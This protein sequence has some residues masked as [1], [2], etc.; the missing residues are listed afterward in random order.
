MNYAARKFLRRTLAFALY[1]S[2]A[3]HLYAAVRLRDRA[4][5]LTYHRVQPESADSY[6]AEGITV[7]P[8]TFARHMRFLS[9][10]FRPLSVEEFRS[11]VAS[12]RFPRRACLVT[13][14]DGWADNETYALPILQQSSVPA[15]LFIATA[16]VGT[17]NTFWQERLTRLLFV[18]TRQPTRGQ[19]L[20]EE[21]G[22]SGARAAPQKKARRMVRDFVTRTKSRDTHAIEVLE[23]RVVAALG[24]DASACAVDFGDDAF[25]DWEAIGRMVA[26]G[27]VTIGSH[28]HSH[29]PLPPM[30]RDG[31]SSEFSEAA[32]IIERH[33]LP[34]PWV[35]AYPN[36][37]VDAAIAEAAKATGHEIGFTTEPGHVRHGDDPLRLRR[38]NVQESSTETEPELLCR[39]LG[40][41]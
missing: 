21:L 34:R 23:Q 40:L 33:G 15:V 41:F 39:I 4:T 35:C 1:W 2:G 26:S 11:C 20:L 18:L 28:A 12:G 31:A 9:E 17:S 7:S 19:Q 16:F 27:L 32:S 25:L 22:I 38:I 29:S 14:D 3:L 37:D 6:S 36:G 5:V 24:D 8:Q 13:F 30:G 10:K